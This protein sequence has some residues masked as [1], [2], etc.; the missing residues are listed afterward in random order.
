LMISR[1]VFLSLPTPLSITVRLRGT[2]PSILFPCLNRAA[3]L[4]TELFVARARGI[5]V[6]RSFRCA[7]LSSPQFH[8]VDSTTTRRPHHV[9]QAEEVDIEQGEWRR[10]DSGRR[11]GRRDAFARR[12]AAGPC[13]HRQQLRRGAARARCHVVHRL[14]RVGMCCMVVSCVL[15]VQ[16][17]SC[18]LALYSHLQSTAAA[19]HS[20]Q[21][22]DEEQDIQLIIAMKKTP[23]KQNN[24]PLRM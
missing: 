22:L 9:A 8:T 10:C 19:S 7:R 18:L 16:V 20:K 11:T 13:R 17:K 12:S 21:L 14:T 3:L 15:V 24:R 23:E 4:P 1:R 6:S 2:H 5:A